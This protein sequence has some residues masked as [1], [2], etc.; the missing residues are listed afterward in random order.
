MSEDQEEAA[1]ENGAI[2]R[3]GPLVIL[4]KLED[5]VD[6]ESL[7]ELDLDLFLD[8]PDDPNQ[9]K[10]SVLHLD[11]AWA[12]LAIEILVENLLDEWVARRVKFLEQLL[13]QVLGPQIEGAVLLQVI[14]EEELLVLVF[15]EVLW[16]GLP[17]AQVHLREKVLCN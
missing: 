9:V 13:D 7:F 16:V 10:E 5:V 4:D 15:N 11:G 14:F 17:R 3:V 1:A 8:L 2:I 12:D 6:V